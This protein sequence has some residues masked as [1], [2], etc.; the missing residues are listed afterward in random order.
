MIITVIG[1]VSWESISYSKNCQPA[2]IN[3]LELFYDQSYV[4]G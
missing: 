2:C 4:N 3:I 1:K